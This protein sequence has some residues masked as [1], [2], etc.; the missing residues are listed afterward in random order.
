MKLYALAFLLIVLSIWGQ[1]YDPEKELAA[2][3]VITPVP[4]ALEFQ[5]DLQRGQEWRGLWVDAWNKGFNSPE[6]V[7]E[8]VNMAVQYGYN[9][10]VVQARRRGDAIY[11]PTAPNTEPRISSLPANFDVLAE[12]IKQAHAN[13]IE[14]HAWITTFLVSTSTLPTSS[15]HV[16]NAHPEYLME[17]AQGEKNISEGYYLDPGNPNALAWNERVVMDLVTHYDIDGIHF[18]YVRYPQ[19]NSGYNPTAIARYNQEYGLTGKPAS[20]DAKFSEWRRRQITDWLR[21]MYA[22]IMMVKPSMKVSAATFAGRSDAFHNRFQDWATWMAEGLIDANFPMNYSKDATIYQTRVQDALKY[23]YGRH[24]YM[25]VGA[26]LIGK[27]D[28]VTQLQYAR[29]AN[30]HGL[31]LFSYANNCVNPGTD[32]IATYQLVKQQVFSTSASVPEM[33][34]KKAAQGYVYCVI[35]SRNDQ[36]PLYNATLKISSQNYNKTVLSDVRGQCSFLNVPAGEYSISCECVGFRTFQGKI[37]V[38]SEKVTSFNLFLERNEISSLIIDN[39]EAQFTGSWTLAN[40]ATDKCGK[41]YCYIGKTG[42]G[43]SAKFVLPSTLQGQYR[44]Y[45]WYSA[46]T[47]RTSQAKYSVNH[48]NGTSSVSINQQQNGGKWNLLGTWSFVIGKSY[49]V[50]IS[51]CL[52]TGKVV[53][54]D[55]IRLEKI[56]K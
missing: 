2:P 46:G 33:P 28:V 37:S 27:N 53:I 36:S 8:V 54:A 32:W 11:F 17:N 1:D 4:S 21:I 47:N 44:I 30:S 43:Y 3:E 12:Y 48:A 13:N 52:E 10:I 35:S 16:C 55:A 40:S 24:V 22:R 25:G 39:P 14:V 41:D 26:Y 51:E 29:N 45:A 6:Q 19:A 56:T 18:D 7:K 20:D 38:F 5:F 31:I 49:S 34:W 50:Q 42:A 23:S 15:K 9:A